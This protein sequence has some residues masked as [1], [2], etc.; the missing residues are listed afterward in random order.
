[1]PCG[2][3][4]HIG[5]GPV[6]EDRSPKAVSWAI[7]ALITQYKPNVVIIGIGDTMA[8]YNQKEL[9]SSWVRENVEDLT[10]AITAR[11]L[12]CIWIGPGWGTEGGPYGKNF[13]RVKELS[14][15]LA[16]TVA[17]CTYI[18]SLT[19]SKPGE[20]ATFDGQHYTN[21]GYE[22]WGAALTATIT[23]N[24]AVKALAKH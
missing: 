24:V 23:A 4:Q 8:G 13:K 20:W 6:T 15:F 14:D 22:K 19:F 2:V 16:S 12:P 1:V 21:V 7:D 3:A 17:P 5:S 18:D 10:A 11:H 9:Q